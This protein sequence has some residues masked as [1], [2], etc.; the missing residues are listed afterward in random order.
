MNEKNSNNSSSTKP[1]I[2]TS[3]EYWQLSVKSMLWDENQL[4]DAGETKQE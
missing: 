4:K 2:L 1:A 3:I